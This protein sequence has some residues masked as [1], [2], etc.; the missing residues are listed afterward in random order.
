VRKLF[1]ALFV[2]SLSSIFPS[3]NANAAQIIQITEP[4]HRLADGVFIDD[5]LATKLLPAGE[6]GILV[7]NTSKSVSSW[8]VDPATISEIVAMSNG[9]GVATGVAPVGQ[10]VAKAWLTQFI[11][12]TKYENVSALTYGNPNIDWL[13]E[14][15]PDQ[16][17]YINAVGKLILED[18]LDKVTGPV[19]NP[20]NTRQ[21]ISKA[22]LN[23]IT[24][25]QK[26]LNLLSTVVDLKEL[27]PYQLRLAQLL[28]PKS[29]D[30]QVKILVKDFNQSITQLRGKL[31][32][33]GKKFTVTSVNQELPIT[34]ANNFDAPVKLK[35]SIRAINSKVVVAPIE[36]IQ[37]AGKSKLQVLLP[38]EVLASGESRLLAQLTNL[39]NKPVGYPIN[40]TLKLSV[41]SPVATWITS[42]AAV[43]LFIALLIQSLRRVR[44][45]K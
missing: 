44:R 3:V 37:V 6:L 17:T 28:S 12:V 10:V 31:K 24:Y 16:L 8:Q 18:V 15:S 21:E 29:D 42:G 35:L 26:Q 2:L 13:N 33:T 23:I 14:V 34:V 38:V 43:L 7:F 22:E 27:Q 9:Y 36:P 30:K 4:T 20:N 1:T 25:A 41:I 19:I 45:K 40:I 11:R 32:I 39:D 5:Q